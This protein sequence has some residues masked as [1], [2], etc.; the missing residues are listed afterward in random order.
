MK[1]FELDGSVLLE[2]KKATYNNSVEFMQS[3]RSQLKH[4]S[5]CSDGH[6]GEEMINFSTAACW[7][8]DS[9]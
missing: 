7:V 4:V 6:S 8:K 2:W 3:P 1:T 5:P 9:D